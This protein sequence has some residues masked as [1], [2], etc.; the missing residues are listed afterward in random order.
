MAITLAQAKA[1]AVTFLDEET[2]FSDHQ[3]TY[4]DNSDGEEYM[5]DDDANS[6]NISTDQDETFKDEL[7]ISTQDVTFTE[8][9]II[10]LG[11]LREEEIDRMIEDGLVKEDDR[12]D[13]SLREKLVF[14]Y[15]EMIL[16]LT[17]GERYP[18]FPLSYAIDNISLPRLVVDSIRIA[19]RQIMVQFD[20][21]NAIQ[22]WLTRADNESNYGAFESDMVALQLAK[23][24]RERVIAYR[25]TLKVN[26]PD[27]GIPIN[28]TEASSR[29]QILNSE[30]GIDPSSYNTSAAIKDLLGKSIPEVCEMIPPHYRILHVENVV[31]STLY[32]DFYLVRQKIKERLL[33]L[34]ASQLRHSVPIE[35]QRKSTAHGD[36]AERREKEMLVDYLTTPKCTFHG[37]QRHA[38]ASIVR[39]GFIRPGDKN[40]ETGETHGIR[41]GNTYGRGIYTSPSAQFSL[42]YS[43]YEACPT[44]ATQFSGL[45]LI[46]CATIMGRPAQVSRADNWREQNE[47]YP[48]ADS[49][50]ANCEYEYIVFHPRQTIPVLV[51]HLDWGKEHYDE[52]VNIPS[53][54]LSWIQQM[55][56]KRNA[57]RTHWKLQG[58]SL[59][60]ADVVKR[61]QALMARALKWFPYGYGPATGTR[62]V[63]EAVADYSDDEE[64]YGE[65]QKDKVEEKDGKDGADYFWERDALEDEDA[66]FDEFFMERK[67]KAKR[68]EVKEKQE[69]DSSL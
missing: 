61:K 10:E 54:P 2:W 22:R 63:I 45:K 21:K 13:E 36:L 66:R 12:F 67:A 18:V 65:Y 6:S 23:E 33:K 25:Q 46:V 37:T 27:V 48:N 51:I 17:T 9:E 41:C 39:N 26:S 14:E 53:N 31:K 32:S 1:E 35:H 42:S 24:T 8:D 59:F 7:Q 29:S 38:V 64:D 68:V 56:Q 44:E 55:R 15:P 11:I 50:V 4:S 49:H 20:D 16:T 62:F 43:G 52:F 69:N 3:D 60:P 28:V 19:L 47:P 30:K 34:R 5:E 40:P 58:V 57:D